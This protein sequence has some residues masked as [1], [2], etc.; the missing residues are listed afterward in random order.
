MHPVD[1]KCGA[2]A[3]QEIKR[4]LTPFVTDCGASA[5][6]EK[7]PTDVMPPSRMRGL[8]LPEPLTLERFVA[9][10]QLSDPKLNK[11]RYHTQTRAS[12]LRTQHPTAKPSRR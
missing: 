2:Q 8:A 6:N 3:T 9:P 4:K 1:M 5:T 10:Q 12:A 7:A 11:N